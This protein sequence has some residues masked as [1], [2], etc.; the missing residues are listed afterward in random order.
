MKPYLYKDYERWEPMRTQ[1]RVFTTFFVLIVLIAGIYFFS[2]WFSKTTGYVLGEDQKIAFADCLA[3]KGAVFYETERC[4]SCEKQRTLFG[5]AAWNKITTRFCDRE[6]RCTG[7][8]SLPAWEIEGT[9]HYG[10]K[11]FNELDA[12]SSC[13]VQPAAS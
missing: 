13:D 12:V 1:T 2:D 11:T 10:F 7:L 5:D 6:T 4:A 3:S 8:S 9:F